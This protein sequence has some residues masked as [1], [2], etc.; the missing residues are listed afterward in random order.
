MKLLY[1]LIIFNIFLFSVTFPKDKYPHF[2]DKNKQLEFSTLKLT[3]SKVNKRI[4]TIQGGGAEFSSLELYNSLVDTLSSIS[5]LNVNEIETDFLFEYEYEIKQNNMVL[6]DI[7]FLRIVG[8]FEKADSTLINYQNLLIQ[9]YNSKAFFYSDAAQSMKILEKNEYKSNVEKNE[10]KTLK[11]MFISSISYLMIQNYN[12]QE[13]IDNHDCNHFNNSFS[14]DR[15]KSYQRNDL[16]IKSSYGLILSYFFYDFFKDYLS[17]KSNY[18]ESTYYKFEE[19]QPLLIQK[20]NR[21]EVDILIN[22]YN[23]LIYNNIQNK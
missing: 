12:L 2:S 14:G 3:V 16:I 8:L 11:K 19:K 1:T 4:S 23:R 13:C 22:H 6:D 10:L 20:L 17:I 18:K 5:I 7:R 21:E 9:Y 15:S